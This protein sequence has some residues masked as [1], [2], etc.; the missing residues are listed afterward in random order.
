MDEA[1]NVLGFGFVE[2]FTE[3]QHRPCSELV[4]SY[5]IIGHK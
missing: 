2:N 5:F 4:L 3:R 1:V